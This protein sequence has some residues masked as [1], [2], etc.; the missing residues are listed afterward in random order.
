MHREAKT[1]LVT[2]GA[3]YIGSHTVVQLIEAGF[4]VVI[5]DN[6]C[7]SKAEVVNRIEK[8]TGVRP[9]LAVG[10]IR[11]RVC[12]RSVFADYPIEAVI[13]FA[14]LKAVGE[15][16]SEPLRYYD[17]NV[18]GSLVLLEE[19]ARA[20]VK[21]LVFSSSAT[22]YG[23]PGLVQYTEQTPVAPVNVY[24]RTKLMVEDVLRDLKASDASW[25]I[26]LLRYFNPV[27]AHVS[28]LIGEDPSGVPNNLM[29][30]IAQVA[31]GKRP[32]LQVFGG[33]YPTEDG[34][35]KRDYI[36]VDDLAAGHLAA[37][38]QLSKSPELLTVNLGTGRPYSVLEMIRA[39]EKASGAPVPYEIVERR[40]GDLPEYYADPSLAEQLM[41]WKA[42]LGIDRM[43]EDTWRW[44][45]MNPGGYGGS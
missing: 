29:P 39:F 38:N 4:Q 33:D 9:T 32:Q 21:T 19:M 45:S 35:G 31:V 30:Y 12:L 41:G 24:G 11:D 44:Q 23:D 8:I 36:H 25:R 20:G 22:V 1:I 13:H 43:C 10:D 16:Q 42:E 37:L 7:N 2:G 40:A 26:A 18:S 5:L 34:T 14:G 17:N 6:L 15:S 27:G 3:G 28:G